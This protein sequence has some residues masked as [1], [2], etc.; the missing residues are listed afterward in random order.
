MK[1]PWEEISLSDY[2]AHMSLDSVQ[3]LQTMNRMIKEQF[4][5][6]P[7]RTAMLL[8]AAG[9][10]GLE[11]AGADKF[12]AVYAVDINAGYLKAI[13][14]RFGTDGVIKCLRA[15]LTDE[16]CVL[17]HTE[18][19]IADLLIEYIGYEAFARTV[20]A[21]SPEYVSCGI[22]INTDEKQWVSDSPYLHAFDGLDAVH[23]QM[24]PD[25]LAAAMR[26][27]GYRELLREEDP[28]PN[29]KSL[30][31]QDFGKAAE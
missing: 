8:G 11:H 14:Q 26:G 18:L 16:E 20:S 1:N 27:I 9:G 24:H 22:Q 3:Q 23:H 13:E 5:A 17:P 30:V 6:Y 19:V 4:A 28:L 29:G 2:E 21:V 25:E 31:R 7:V 10:N 15:D 12:T